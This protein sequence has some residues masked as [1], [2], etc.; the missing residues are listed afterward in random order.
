MNRSMSFLILF[1]LFLPAARC[2]K[3]EANQPLESVGLFRVDGKKPFTET[4]YNLVPGLY[5]E[6]LHRGGTVC[7]QSE[8]RCAPPRGNDLSGEE[9]WGL[10]LPVGDDLVHIRDRVILTVQKETPLRFYVPDGE[11]LA[12]ADEQTPLYADNSGYWEI[13]VLA[14][15][16]APEPEF[17]R[18]VSVTSYSPDGY[19][20]TDMVKQLNR[21]RALGAN[22]VQFVPVVETDGERIYPA[23]HS[24]RTICLVKA[25]QIALRM[26][27]RVTW[28]LHVDPPGDEWRGAL[29]PE[30]HDKFF[31]EYRETAL[32]YA[33]LAQDY[34]VHSFVPATEMV[35]LMED[36]EDRDRW[37]SLFLELHSVF[38][39][40][41]FYAADRTEYH[42]LGLDFW[43]N[44]C[45]AVGITPW[46]TLT[47]EMHPSYE[48][49]A[50]AWAPIVEELEQFAEK[51]KMR[52]ILSEGPGY[53][54]IE[55]CNMAPAEYWTKRKGDVLCQTEAYKAFLNIFSPSRKNIIGGHFLWEIT[56]PG[57]EVSEYSPLDRMTESILIQEWTQK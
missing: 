51:T 53:R 52:I 18:G 5:Y 45:D 42:Y 14:F 3:P 50:N 23:D 9:A 34:G 13:E 1:C 30:D 21:I 43:H 8:R 36:E 54:A 41:I 25:T 11:H 7:I 6:F 28:N 12:W 31:A 24:P 17:I 38:F 32:L 20:S 10:Y 40:S 35:S 44:C 27:L 57:E 37:L 49:L 48:E 33:R 46:Y 2:S 56:A 19:C 22:A 55:G 15:E 4:G 39:G 16:E 26:G 47:T 29:K